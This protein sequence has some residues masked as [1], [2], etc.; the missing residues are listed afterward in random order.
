MHARY[1]NARI[2]ARKNRRIDSSERMPEKM[3]EC[4]PDII[5]E[6]MQDTVPEQ[7]GKYTDRIEWQEKNTYMILPD[8]ITE[9]TTKQKNHGG[10]DSK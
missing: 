9:T 2:D 8:E 3:S 6:Q 10:D 1:E 5:S 4:M 7:N